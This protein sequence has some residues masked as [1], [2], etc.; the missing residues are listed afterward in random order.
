M[1]TVLNAINAVEQA[2]AQYVVKPLAVPYDHPAYV[3]L[4]AA[5]EA[6]FESRRDALRF[7]RASTQV[8]AADAVLSTLDALYAWSQPLPPGCSIRNGYG[9]DVVAE[10]AEALRA[11]VQNA[12]AQ[13]QQP[14]RQV[15][16]LMGDNIMQTTNNYE[17]LCQLAAAR[18]AASDALTA[19]DKAAPSWWTAAGVYTAAM[20][21][22]D[23]ALAANAELVA[24]LRERVIATRATA[25]EAHTAALAGTGSWDGYLAASRVQQEAEEALCATGANLHDRPADAAD[26][27]VADLVEYTGPESAHGAQPLQLRSDEDIENL[28]QQWRYDPTWDIE[29][30][31]GFELHREKLLA[32]RQECEEQWAKRRA[33][34]SRQLQVELAARAEE[35]GI[36]GNVR[37][38]RYI[39]SL[40]RRINAL[41][42]GFIERGGCVYD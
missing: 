31:E 18:K 26:E 4:E 24:E 22:L 30:T 42:R 36:A 25:C 38:V 11:A 27:P 34:M 33:E 8:G 41:E 15:P 39:E 19:E 29:T 14:P 40:E 5:R 6:L 9:L 28:K 16:G 35:L 1:Q 21:A 17:T 23:E 32:Y 10:G 20:Q 3:A 13:P 37:L 7:F 12:T 2:A